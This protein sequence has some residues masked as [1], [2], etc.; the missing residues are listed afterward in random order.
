MATPSFDVSIAAHYVPARIGF[1]A[2]V[3]KAIASWARPQVSVTVVTND[4]AIADEPAMQ[5]CTDS[6]R[7]RG[8]EVRYDLAHGMAHPFHL[9]WWHKQHL[10]EWHAREGTPQDLFMYIEDDIVVTAENIAYFAKYLDAAKAKGFI[11]GFLRFEKLADGTIMNPDYRGIQEVVEAHKVVLDGQQ[12]FAPKFSYW[13][14]FIMDRDLCSEYFACWRSRIE[15][16]DRFKEDPGDPR[17]QSARGLTFEKVPAGAPSRYIVPVDA[18]DHPLPECLVWHSANNY[19]VSKA[20]NFGTV[21]MDEI[22]RKPGPRAKARQAIWNMGAF[23]RR[24][25]DKIRRT[26]K[27]Q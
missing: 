18:A 25:F 10:K 19:V 3:M 6:L 8:Y 12:F 24:V 2:E 13:A 23:R 15:N 17:V 22:F 1:L 14:G 5:S 11:P 21:R 7:A 27:G 16:L 4:L 20:W 9:T 26:L